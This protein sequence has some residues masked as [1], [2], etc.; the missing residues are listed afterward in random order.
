MQFPAMCVFLSRISWDIV[1]SQVSQLA[2]EYLG[3]FVERRDT[4]AA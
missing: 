1:L 4:R 3:N 2:P